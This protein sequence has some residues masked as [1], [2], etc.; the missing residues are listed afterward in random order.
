MSHNMGTL[1]E[2]GVM[3][4]S[5]WWTSLNEQYALLSMFL[6]AFF[7]A[8]LLPGNSEVVF[9]A[10]LASP[11]QAAQYLTMFQLLGVAVIGNSLGSLTTYWLGRLLPQT[12][13]R[14]QDHPRFAKTK[15]LL[16]RYGAYALFF[17][18]L[19]LFGDLLCGVAGYLRIHAL[20]SLLFILLGKTLRYAFLLLLAMQVF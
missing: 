10:L 12:Q 2:T 14:Q 17:S 1:W 6:S 19:P 16:Q 18:W 13:Q 4:I 11:M 20:W 5:T 15:A 7:S 8:T 9:M 3:W